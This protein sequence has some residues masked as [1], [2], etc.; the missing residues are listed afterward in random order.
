MGWGDSSL[1]F[2]ME[3]VIR[4]VGVGSRGIRN[5]GWAISI[6]VHAELIS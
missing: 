4:R 6:V 5:K 3:T 1:P 2:Y